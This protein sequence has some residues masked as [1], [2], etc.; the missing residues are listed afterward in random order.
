MRGKTIN[1]PADKWKAG[2]E[3]QYLARPDQDR[4]VCLFF[5]LALTLVAGLRSHFNGSRP[6]SCDRAMRQTHTGYAT[7]RVRVSLCHASGY[8]PLSPSGLSRGDSH[9]ARAA[10]TPTR[11][12]LGGSA[13]PTMAARR[14]ARGR[15]ESCAA[16]VQATPQTTC[17]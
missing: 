6:C 16:R 13:I 9:G 15:G 10:H 5:A 8:H 3:W 1:V 12:M 11:C 14:Y 4:A 17:E 7:T 2:S